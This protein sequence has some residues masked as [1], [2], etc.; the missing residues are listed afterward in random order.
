MEK[1]Y[2][3]MTAALELATEWNDAAKEAAAKT[4]EMVA[5]AVEN[6]ASWS[7]I[8]EALGLSKQTAYARYGKAKA[9]E[10]RQDKALEQWREAMKATPSLSKKADAAAPAKE[11]KAS[12]K[13]DSKEP[14]TAKST[15]ITGITVGVPHTGPRT[16]HVIP[17]PDTTA[18]PGIGKGMGPH[19]C[20]GCGD[21]NHKTESPK[22][23]EFNA[24]CVPTQY[25]PPKIAFLMWET[26]R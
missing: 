10:E 17:I 16:Q 21:N 5:R 22:F 13:S 1:N 2:A 19:A 11:K 4:A 23:A 12:K 3:H 15:T 14:A 18:Q 9:Q 7:A 25:D 20:P 6:G 8:G 26:H 24:D